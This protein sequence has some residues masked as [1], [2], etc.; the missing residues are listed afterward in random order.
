MNL[1]KNKKGIHER[2]NLVVT[3]FRGRKGQH[4]TQTSAYINSKIEYWNKWQVANFHVTVFKEIFSREAFGLLNW[5]FF[6][7]QYSLTGLKHEIN[8]QNKNNY[9]VLTQHEQE[10]KVKC[11][12]WFILALLTT[13]K[14]FHSSEQHITHFEQAH[15][16]I[17]QKNE[18]SK[19]RQQ[20]NNQH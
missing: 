12:M 5:H 3:L 9:T 7:I 15:Y 10:T 6:L 17:Y 19:N 2:I 16:C 14:S 4:L 1:F 18:K 8:P 13:L 20:I 11:S